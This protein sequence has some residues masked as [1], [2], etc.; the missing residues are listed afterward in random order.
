MLFPGAPEPATLES[1]VQ[2]VDSATPL[3][4]PPPWQLDV[5]LVVRVPESVSLRPRWWERLRGV[6]GLALLVLGV[7]ST[8]ALTAGFAVL[9]LGRSIL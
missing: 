3:P 7:A 8:I 6:A 1:E 5:P 2:R 4:P 9:L